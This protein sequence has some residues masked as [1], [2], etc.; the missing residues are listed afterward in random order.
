MLFRAHKEQGRKTLH[1]HWQIWVEELLPQVREDLWHTDHEI[2]RE[3][4][5]SFTIMLMKS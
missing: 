5:K 3:N 1:S 2:R 4:I